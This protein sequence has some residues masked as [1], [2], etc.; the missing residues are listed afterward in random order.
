MFASA[1]GDNKTAD[2]L[3]QIANLFMPVISTLVAVNKKKVEVDSESDSESESESES[4]KEE[5]DTP[6]DNEPELART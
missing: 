3:T 2:H 5:G 6:E 1:T 4:D